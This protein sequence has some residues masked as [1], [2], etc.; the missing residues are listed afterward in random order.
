MMQP[1]HCCVLDQDQKFQ[2]WQKMSSLT[3]PEEKV[4]KCR[5]RRSVAVGAEAASPSRRSRPGRSPRQSPAR[6]RPSGCRR[7]AF[8]SKIA[9]IGCASSRLSLL[10]ALVPHKTLKVKVRYSLTSEAHTMMMTSAKLACL[11]SDEKNCLFNMS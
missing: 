8:K 3:H 4:R 11:L 5:P 10:P 9:P 2:F 1:C 7:E 6:S